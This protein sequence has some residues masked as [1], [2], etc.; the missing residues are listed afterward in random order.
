MI[1][2]ILLVLACFSIVSVAQNKII[3]IEVDANKE[4][5]DLKPIWAWFAYDEPNYTYM[6]NGKKLLPPPA[7]FGAWERQRLRARGAAKR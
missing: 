1:K 5:G 7:T 3:N 4:T 6:K 2:H